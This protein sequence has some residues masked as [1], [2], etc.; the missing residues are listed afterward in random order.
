MKFMKTFILVTLTFLFFLSVGA[1][2][3]TSYKIKSLYQSPAGFGISA[4]LSSAT[5]DSSTIEAGTNL[6]LPSIN[7]KSNSYTGPSSA[8][9]TSKGFT[10]RI[11]ELSISDHIV[12]AT[13]ESVE[14]IMRSVEPDMLDKFIQQYQGDY[15]ELMQNLGLKVNCDDDN[16]ALR[17]SEVGS[18][19]LLLRPYGLDETHLI[20]AINGVS[21]DEI[22][23]RDYAFVKALLFSQKGALELVHEANG[24]S[25]FTK[26]SFN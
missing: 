1:A 8:V 18:A 14:S 21:V 17:I 20:T 15:A 12:R 26:I 2:Y 11:P 16:C 23:G 24:V 7:D 10:L 3:F 13:K 22:V 9:V 5:I 6:S 25:H 19:V 4:T